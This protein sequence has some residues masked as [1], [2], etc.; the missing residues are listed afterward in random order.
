MKTVDL[1]D[2]SFWVDLSNVSEAHSDDI[3]DKA[4]ERV[5]TALLE[6]VAAQKVLSEIRVLKARRELAR[7]DVYPGTRILIDYRE[8]QVEAIY[9]DIIDRLPN[10]IVL[11]HI[12]K[13]GEPYKDTCTTD[14]S[15]VDYIT[16]KPS[17]NGKKH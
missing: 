14:I 7:K 2:F 15:S 8:G 1:K 17:L 16:R 5:E 10:R 9:E 6:L 4:F 11:R 3:E 13:R 12:T